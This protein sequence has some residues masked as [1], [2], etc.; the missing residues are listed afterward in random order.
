RLY[1]LVEGEAAEKQ[2]RFAE[3]LHSA[4][5]RDAVLLLSL[6]RLAKR[7]GLWGKAR[8]YLEESLQVHPY[9]ETYHELATLL[10]QEG[11]NAAAARCFQDGLA[12]ATYSVPG[13]RRRLEDKQDKQDKQQ[14]E[15]SEG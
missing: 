1:G 3:R 12:L 13:A 8:S 7:N 6:G 5:A 4:H 9:P 2:L 14:T 15:K 11:D 10:V